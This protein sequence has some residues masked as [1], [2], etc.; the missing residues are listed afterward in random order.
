MWLIIFILAAFSV[1]LTAIN[2]SEAHKADQSVGDIAKETKHN[3]TVKTLSIASL[4]IQGII[5]LVFLGQALG[6]LGISLPNLQWL[7]IW[8]DIK[9][10]AK[11]KTATDGYKFLAGSSAIASFI[12]LLV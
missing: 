1:I 4:A 7:F 11:S 2:V 5:I 10:A 6:A 12:T 3:D 9:E 8:N